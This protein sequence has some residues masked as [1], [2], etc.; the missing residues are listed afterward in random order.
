MDMP[1]IKFS[2]SLIDLFT[3]PE[4]ISRGDQK[5][6]KTKEH[7]SNDGNGRVVSD[8]RAILAREDEI[9]RK[10]DRIGE[11]LLI[12]V[13]RASPDGM[14]CE[15][16]DREDPLPFRADPPDGSF[17]GVSWH[18][19]LTYGGPSG[20]ALGSRARWSD[21]DGVAAEC[22]IDSIGFAEAFASG[23]LAL[24]FSDVADWLESEVR[25]RGLATEDRLREA[26]G[27]ARDLARDLE[28]LR[29]QSLQEPDRMTGEDAHLRS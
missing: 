28:T 5:V 1:P 2:L 8:L 16:F 20:G 24:F 3:S 15:R 23:R 25:P 29:D 9:R 21:S 6:C 12:E 27:I 18:L 26:R 17:E 14:E 7:R 19:T 10:A 11:L 4:E 22:V 13:V